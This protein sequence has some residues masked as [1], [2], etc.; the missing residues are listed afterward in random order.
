M[1]KIRTTLE[2]LAPV[3]AAAALFTLAGCGDAPP[4]A[5]ATPADA[6]GGNRG[7]IIP[8]RMM[9]GESGAAKSAPASGPGVDEAPPPAPPPAAEPQGG[10][11]N[12]A[13]AP[14]KDKGAEG[15]EAKQRPGLGT[16]WGETKVSRISRTAFVRAD[17]TTPFATASLYYNDQAGAR[18]IAG[19]SQLQAVPGGSFSVGGGTVSIGLKDQSGHF[20]SAFLAGGKQVVVGAAGLNYA[21]VVKNNTDSRFECVLSVDGLD[22]LDGKTAA[23]AK[24]GYIINA[25]GQIEVEGFRQSMDAVASFRFG[26]VESS[27]SNQ[28]H[29][30]VRNVGV[31]GVALFNEQGG[32]TQ[33]AV[34]QRKDANPFPGN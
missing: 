26:S 33:D 16:E 25:R 10:A 30:E 22:V 24:L 2:T 20:F 3:I 19:G 6:P 23:F 34:Q 7:I 21:I 27:Y 1:F 29:G 5:A 4:P 17:P 31:I 13:P 15:E 12:K 11:A 32:W 8:Q 9:S 14:K 28:K 18:A